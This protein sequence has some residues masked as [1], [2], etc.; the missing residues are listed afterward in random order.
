MMLSVCI[1]MYNE[2]LIISDTFDTLYEFLGKFSEDRGIK[3]EL[4]FFDDGS[5]D[6]CADIVRQKI[7]SKAANKIDVKVSGYS[8]NKGKG[9]AV[10]NAVL[11]S[12]GDIVIFTDSDLAYG[13]EVIGK[14]YLNLSDNAG[15]D[16]LIGSRNIG[17]GGYDGYTFLRKLMSKIY[18]KIINIATGFSHSDSQCGFKAFRG[19]CARDIFS[20]CENNGFAFDIEVLMIALKS[21]YKISE[22]LVKIINHRQSKVRIVH[23]SVK[24]LA[25]I[26]KIKK[27]VKRISTL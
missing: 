8:V 1:P 9:S 7:R 22:M 16:I 23:D 10:R 11:L 17:E 15:T 12:A 24:M 27:N 14:A 5:I 4:I 3:A 25:D 18:I 26:Q 2:S 6:G 13:C 19:D 20:K 21:G